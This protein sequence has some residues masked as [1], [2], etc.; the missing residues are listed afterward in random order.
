[1]LHCSYQVFK[2]LDTPFGE[3]VRCGLPDGRVFGYWLME[4][5]LL[6]SSFFFFLLCVPLVPLNSSFNHTLGSRFL[7][8]FQTYFIRPEFLIDALIILTPSL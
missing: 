8:I 4:L 1:M 2:A 7:I 5:R 3:P 6:F